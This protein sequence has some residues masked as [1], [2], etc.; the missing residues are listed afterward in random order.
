MLLHIRREEYIEILQYAQERNVK[1]IPEFNMPAHARA[2]VVA[3]EARSKK[4]DDTYRLTDPLD[5]TDLLTVQFYD[6]K[7][8]INPC[9]DSSVRFVEKLVEEVKRM[10][11][12]AGVP[13]DS[14]HF[15]GVSEVS[16]APVHYLLAK[17]T[18][19]RS[20]SCHS[21]DEAKNILL[22]AGYSSVPEDMKQLPFSK[23]PSCQTKIV[24]DP[25]FDIEKIANYWALKVNAILAQNGIREMIAWED[26]LRGTTKEQYE[27][28][29]V[30]VNFWETLFWG[31]IDGLTSIADDGLDIIMAN[32]DYL[33]FD[34]P[35][36]V[37]PE[38][39]G[40]YWGARFNSVY[41]VFTFAPE[42][43]AQ[44]A[45]TST[46]RDGNEMSVITPDT[47][48][49]KIRGM[50]GQTWSE[51]IRTDDQYYEMAFPRVLAV[52]ERAWH[53][54]AWEL[55][56]SPSTTYN[57]TS[58]HVPKFELSE[59]YNGFVSALGCRE[60]VKLRKLGI[61]YRVPP[62]GAAIDAS[63]VLTANSELPCAAIAYST[64]EGNTWTAYSGPVYVGAGVSV[65]LR[66][67]SYD[68]ALKSRV[69]IVD[70]IAAL[71]GVPPDNSPTAN[72][73]S[74]NAIKLAS[75][76]HVM[77]QMQENFNHD[78]D[79]SMAD[80][81]LCYTQNLLLDYWGDGDYMDK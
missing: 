52:A 57:L 5:E 74:N 81:T 58:G 38:E 72:I 44:N 55:D 41:K 19:M 73:S 7:S 40:Y 45:E 69:E 63:G 27:T 67:E 65:A 71:P 56:W 43:F 75:N 16:R 39:R 76:L 34:F 64:D 1:I 46:D 2:A 59:D 8:I 79:C 60:L 49:P 12:E 13:L 18:H 42:N 6:R 61:L 17:A 15:G 66:S 33:Y 11:D 53:R 80:W 68:G 47:A 9:L 31:G 10:H 23:S 48:K 14:Y 54:A 70:A 35:Y 62:P 3:M 37:N 50:Q 20:I 77:M 29:S 36:E 51:T 24:E 28:P 26:G 32:P 30:A 22:G 4:G 21:K 25:S 78:A